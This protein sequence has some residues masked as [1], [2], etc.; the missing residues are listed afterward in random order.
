M[1]A[2]AALQRRSS[3][4][5]PH[6]SNLAPHG[7]PASQRMLRPRATPT[8][9]TPHVQ[10]TLSVVRL[11]GSARASATTP[12]SPIWFPASREQ[13][14]PQQ[15]PPNPPMRAL[16]ALPRRSATRSAP[17]SSHHIA[18]PHRSA[19]PDREPHQRA[20]RRTYGRDGASSDSA[21]VRAPAPPHPQL[22]FGSLQAAS[23]RRFAC[24][25]K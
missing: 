8:S 16:V 23:S 6:S 12:A 3:A 15:R 24:S 9:P 22:R 13:T 20:P 18:T 10:R 7:D 25:R 14:D 21:A 11:G 17:S 4:Q 1:R 19:C 2:L 5:G